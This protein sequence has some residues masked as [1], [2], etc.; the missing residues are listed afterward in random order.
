[1]YVAVRAEVP[2]DFQS[3]LQETS[4]PFRVSAAAIFSLGICQF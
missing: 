4:L 3:P 2:S 1:M